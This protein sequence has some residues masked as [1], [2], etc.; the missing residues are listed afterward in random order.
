VLLARGLALPFQRA[1]KALQETATFDL[2]T[3]LGGSVV[4][5]AGAAEPSPAKDL[6]VWSLEQHAAFHAELAFKP[7]ERPALLARYG[8]TEADCAQ[9][10]AHWWTELQRDAAQRMAW[11]KARAVHLQR[12]AQ[13]VA[14]PK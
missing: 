5:N 10:D 8:I 6:P 4:P 2:A 3:M 12:L 11:E 13:M 14:D 9:L 7:A 1:H